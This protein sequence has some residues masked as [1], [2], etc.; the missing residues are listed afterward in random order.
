MGSPHKALYFSVF[1]RHR[2]FDTYAVLPCLIH[3]RLV[4]EYH[5]I[6]KDLFAFGAHRRFFVHVQPDPVPERVRKQLAI[7]VFF[8][9]LPSDRVRLLA[10]HTR[11]DF[12]LCQVMRHQNVRVRLFEG[13][14]FPIIAKQERPRNIRTIRTAGKEGYRDSVGLLNEIASAYVDNNFTTAGRSFG[15][16]NGSIGTIDESSNPI[17][18]EKTYKEGNNS[19]PYKDSLHKDDKAIIKENEVLQTSEDVWFASRQM[20]PSEEHSYFAVR[21]FSSNNEEATHSLYI[22]RQ[23]KTEESLGSKAFG[24]RPIVYLSSDVKISSGSGTSNQ[25]YILSK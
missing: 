8:E 9:I 6:A 3:A 11:H 12:F 10:R 7:A 23:N 5:M 24:V 25:P 18:W 1:Q 22:S 4:R 16:G 19:L 13:F 2:I 20:I 14:V 21:Y 17:T 15:S